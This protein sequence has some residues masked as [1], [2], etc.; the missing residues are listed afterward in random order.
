MA[1]ADGQEHIERVL[2]SAGTKIHF[3]SRATR[4]DMAVATWL[5]APE[6]FQM[7]RSELRLT[8]LV[9]FEYYGASAPA[10]RPP[11]FT[12]HP[13]QIHAMQ[14]EMDEWFC[15]HGRGEETTQI[16]AHSMDDEW[17]FLVRH[18]DTYA[19]KAKVERRHTE[20]LHYRPAKDDVV[21]YCPQRDDLRIHAGTAGETELYRQVFGRRLFGSPHYF[22]ERKAYTLAPLRLDGPEAL[23][24]HDIAGIQKI[25]LREIEVLSP[26]RASS[27]VL[28]H[29]CDLFAENPSGL[30]DGQLQRARFDVFFNRSA[31][32][33]V[34]EI[35]PPNVLKLGRHCD[36]APVHRWIG[37]R[38][39]RT[40]PRS[41]CNDSTM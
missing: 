18:G 13:E 9:T 28:A 7:A 36:A 4:A 14:A 24:V 27:T 35:R 12:P 2:A 40:D 39:F 23:R 17:W 8:R 41:R 6:A 20:L 25:K 1:C 11:G 31:R 10:P 34:V 16:Q 22:N 38:G 33:R 32:P 3:P 21:V 26:E 5:A 19:S 29:E 30:P 37:K 15:R